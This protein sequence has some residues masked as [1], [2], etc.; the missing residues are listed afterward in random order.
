MRVDSIMSDKP[1]SR[2][3]A[4]LKLYVDE[5]IAKLNNPLPTPLRARPSIAWL[6]F[7]FKT[8]RP[9]DKTNEFLCVHDKFYW[10]T[11]RRCNRG[12]EGARYWKTK[13]IP[14]LEELLRQCTAEPS[15]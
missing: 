10:T 12:P 4:D 1:I 2:I 13:L 7:L 5:D 8:R 3:Y 15:K 11:C 6:E 14:R 9:L